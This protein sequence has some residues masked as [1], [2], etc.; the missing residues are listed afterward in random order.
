[1]FISILT[2]LGNTRKILHEVSCH[3]IITPTFADKAL[4]EF[5]DFMTLVKKNE[6][7]ELYKALCLN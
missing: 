7:L 1:M 4:S 2:S 6:K 5:G 3:K